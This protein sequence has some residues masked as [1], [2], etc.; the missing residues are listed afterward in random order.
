MTKTFFVTGTD[1]DVGKTISCMA[2][3]QAAVQRGLR[4]VGYKPVAAGCEL[5]EE[6]LCN[7]D[8]V[9]LQH[10]ANI[11]LPYD[12]VVGYAFEPAVAPH[13]AA[14]ASG[15]PI[16]FDVLSNG[17]HQLKQTD[18]DI[19]FVEGAGGWRLP[20]GHGHF[21]SDWVKFE[22]MPVILVIGARIGCLNH[23]MLTY[24]AIRHDHLNLAGWCLNQVHQGM[25]HYEENLD[26]LQALLPAPFLGQIPYLPRPHESDLGQYL[27]ISPLLD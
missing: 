8:V 9:M 1:T 15:V 20:V 11:K 7:R 16:R 18:A 3:L 23:A 4:T 27:D 22:D 19:L 24:E 26:T 21:L 13:I 5:M 17:L 6:G 2:L 12:Q 25:S 10:A 14:E